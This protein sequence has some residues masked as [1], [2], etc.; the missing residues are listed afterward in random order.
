MAYTLVQTSALV[1]GTPGASS[2]F[3]SPVTPGNL[4]VCY[5]L[6]SYIS[7]TPTFDGSDNQGN[8]SYHV[9]NG[10][11]RVGFKSAIVYQYNVASDGGTFTVSIT[12]APGG[13]GFQCQEWSGFGTLDPAFASGAIATGGF[14][15]PCV[16]S[17]DTIRPDALLA[18]AC[19]TAN[20][21]SA[22]PE[23]AS[24]DW[25]NLYNF[26]GFS[27]RADYRV[28]SSAGTQEIIYDCGGGT[29]Q[30][31]VVFQNPEDFST[32]RETQIVR[33]FVTQAPS[34]PVRATQVVQGVVAQ[35]PI[36]TVRVTQVVRVL[37]TRPSISNG[38]IVIPEPTNTTLWKLLRLDLKKRNEEEA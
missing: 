11:D 24:P 15:V 20:F 16:A 26:G 13:I 21:Q 30:V 17:P 1:T 8:G 2:S 14:T 38:P 3:P 32:I 5:V 9:I 33:G 22:T 7:N 19:C 6:G 34:A 35:S 31:L 18:A 37:I 28:V 23:T 12:G 4:I 36:P 29:S 27:G 25:T 10:V